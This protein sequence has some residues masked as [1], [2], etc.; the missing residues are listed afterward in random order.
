MTLRDEDGVDHP[1]WPVCWSSGPNRPSPRLRLHRCR[2][3]PGNPTA[4]RRSHPCRTDRQ[5]TPDQID[6]DIA[7]VARFMQAPSDK[8]PDRG[9]AAPH[10][11]DVVD[12]AIVN[13]VVHSDYAIS[14]RISACSCPPTA[15]SSTAPT[16][17]PSTTCPTA[18][19]HA[20]SFW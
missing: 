6:A 4:L 12:E 7:F 2:V 13:A 15:W 14:A 17:S 9:D 16:P 20:T 8:R 1:P 11:L 5:P 18:L 19:L 10:D 3:L